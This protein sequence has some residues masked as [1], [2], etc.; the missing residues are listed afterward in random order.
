M[1]FVFILL[2][3]GIHSSD[4]HSVSLE[5]IKISAGKFKPTCSFEISYDDNEV[6]KAVVTCSK[7]K[8]NVG[9]IQ[10]EFFTKTRHKIAITFT[11]RKGKNTAN[12]TNK[13]VEMSRI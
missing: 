1:V 5:N 3:P 9:G 7:I 6:S 12:V 4:S 2:F 8:K 13:N 11:L 10:Y